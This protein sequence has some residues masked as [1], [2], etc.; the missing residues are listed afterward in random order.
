M[1]AGPCV[2]AI[3]REPAEFARLAAELSAAGIQVN[4][5]QNLLDALLHQVAFSAR[6]VICDTDCVDWKAALTVFRCL[7]AAAIVFLA[8]LADEPLWLEML[9]AGAFDLL[10]KPYDR[11]ELTRITA[12]VFQP[13]G[14][15]KTGHVA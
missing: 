8:R 6:L 13:G 5:A 10:P 1:N 11:R 4:R 2:L 9:N 7:P 14:P 12:R 15:A 3:V